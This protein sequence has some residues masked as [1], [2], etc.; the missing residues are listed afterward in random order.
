MLRTLLALNRLYR[1]PFPLTLTFPIWK[2]R[3]K[4]V[5]M[6]RNR[7]ANWV[8]L[9]SVLITTLTLQVAAPRHW[10]RSRPRDGRISA[11]VYA[12]LATIGIPGLSKY[13]ALN[14]KSHGS[15]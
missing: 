11:F 13:S 8:L 5:S 10:P 6:C 14:W 2:D 1:S 15:G 4:R 3:E 9:G 7:S 12:R